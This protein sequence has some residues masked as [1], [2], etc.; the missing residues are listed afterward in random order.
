MRVVNH[1][2]FFPIEKARE[3]LSIYSLC[4]SA[5]LTAAAAFLYPR[6][7]AIRPGRVCGYKITKIQFDFLRPLCVYTTTLVQL[8][9]RLIEFSYMESK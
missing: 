4:I 6:G 8:L 3:N 5:H 1:F 9:V 7:R 2:P